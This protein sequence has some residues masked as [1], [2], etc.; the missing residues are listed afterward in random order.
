VVTAQKRGVLTPVQ[1][2]GREAKMI[3]DQSGQGSFNMGWEGCQRGG[4]L[5]E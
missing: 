4:R 3:A 5:S 1:S 2:V